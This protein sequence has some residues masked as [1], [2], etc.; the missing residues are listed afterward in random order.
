MRLYQDMIG[1]CRVGITGREPT[2][3]ANYWWDHAD[4]EQKRILLIG[5]SS[6]R[7]IRSIFAEW[8]GYAVDLFAT[9]SGLHDSLFIH[10]IDAFFA[11][12][13]YQYETIF[14]QL[15]HHSRIGDTGQAY[16]DQDYKQFKHDFNC[17]IEYLKQF[18]DQIVIESIFFSVK[19][20]P[21]KVNEKLKIIFRCRDVYDD[22]I[23]LVK[24]KK[25]EILCALAEHHQIAFCDINKILMSNKRYLHY[26]HI[27]YEK[28]AL[29]YI[30]Q[31]LAKY[32]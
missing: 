9:S 8:T 14:V 29:P 5:D 1:Y 6:A 16:T 27:H 32:L 25:N 2:E 12:N 18:S 4:T 31:E 23:N 19:A 20:K 24:K 10:Q 3:W 15:G 13:D 28:K 17:L 21:G 11:Q 30:A 26:D 22:E 7:H